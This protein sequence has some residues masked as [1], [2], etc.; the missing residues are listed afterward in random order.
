M[1]P[2]ALSTHGGDQGVPVGTKLRLVGQRLQST[3]KRSETGPGPIHPNCIIL[4]Q[5]SLTKLR[6]HEH[7]GEWTLTGSHQTI[8]MVSPVTDSLSQNRAE[9][10]KGMSEPPGVLMQKP[11]WTT[12]TQELMVD[13]YDGP[14]ALLK[15]DA[16]G[17][18][19]LALWNDETPCAE[20]WLY[21][22]LNTRN[23]RDLLTGAITIQDALNNRDFVFFVDTDR[24][25]N[26]IRTMMTVP[27]T[28]SAHHPAAATLP[29]ETAT[30]RVKEPVLHEWEEMVQ[31][32]TKYGTQPTP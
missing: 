11:L 28:I 23:L 13:Y 22:P 16:N 7:N 19:Y 4:T 30:L 24:Q 32:R 27:G 25:G 14:R 9:N 12:F 8:I 29:A 20:R 26:P 1:K 6:N 3:A 5:K 31:A 17:Q 18:Q 21:I 10:S 15:L 2:I